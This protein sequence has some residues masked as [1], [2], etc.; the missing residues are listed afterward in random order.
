MGLSCA[1]GVWNKRA[2]AIEVKNRFEELAEGDGETESGECSVKGGCCGSSLE[3]HGKPG[4]DVEKE[5][6]ADTLNNLAGNHVKRTQAT[7]C[8]NFKAGKRAEKEVIADYVNFEREIYGRRVMEIGQVELGAKKLT[9][10]SSIQFNVTDA[11]RPL[12]SAVK[13]C[14]A[15]NRVHLDKNGGYVENEA[16]GERMQLRKSRGTYVFD[17]QYSINGEEDEV[18]VDSGAGVSV[19]PKDKLPELETKSK[20]AGLRMVAANG[21]E[22]QNYGQKLVRFRG[23]STG[24]AG[25]RRRA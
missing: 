24:N 3:V 9:R 19:W 12:V 15:G 6:I 21:T 16:T 22:M 4:K 5:F 13:I 25:F 23:G 14:E 11:R 8:M 10:E 18:T 7:D 17:V 1:K 2:R 20:I